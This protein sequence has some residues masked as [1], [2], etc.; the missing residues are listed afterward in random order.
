MEARNLKVNHHEEE[1]EKSL[2]IPSVYSLS[3]CNYVHNR[4]VPLK[5]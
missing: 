3:L 1:R 5:N 2:H 4:E